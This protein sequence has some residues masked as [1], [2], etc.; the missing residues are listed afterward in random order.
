MKKVRKEK[1][2]RYTKEDLEAQLKKAG[3]AGALAKAMGKHY[4]SVFSALKRYGI[5]K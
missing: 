1:K 2:G 3:N 5:K 4:S